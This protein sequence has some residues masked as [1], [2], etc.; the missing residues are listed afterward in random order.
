MNHD[1]FIYRK[2]QTVGKIT[3]DYRWY[4]IDRE[5][6]EGVHFHGSVYLKELFSSGVSFCNSHGFHAMGIECH[7]KEPNYEGHKPAPCYCMV[8]LGDCY[9]DGSS[10]QAEERLGDVNPDGSEDDRI[11]SVLHE[12]YGYWIEKTVES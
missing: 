8:T 10:L 11:W 12:Y 2:T 9:C 3:I 4:L 1:K 5:T 7:R 6:R